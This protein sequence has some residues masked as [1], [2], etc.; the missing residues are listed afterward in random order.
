VQQPIYA[1]APLL[2]WRFSKEQ[3]YFDAA[4]S[5]M[6][7]TLGLN[8]MGISYVTGLG[9]HQVHNPH[10]RQSWYTKSQ[11][12]WGVPVPGITVFGPGISPNGTTVPALNSLPKERQWCD[13]QGSISSNEFTIFETMTH[14]AL[15]TVL[16][17]GGKWDPS[18][19]PYHSQPSVSP[20]ANT[21]NR[22]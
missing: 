15:Y 19:D 5:L 2:Y 11:P 12:T 4:A 1:C 22:Q 18:K 8:P 7:Y 13:N 9:F 3:S 6:N 17:N 16:A 14:Y 10:D 21:A 20:R